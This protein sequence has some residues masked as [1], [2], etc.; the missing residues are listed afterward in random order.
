M[1]TKL[2]PTIKN[3]EKV[4]VLLP[5]YQE[6]N[7]CLDLIP[8][9]ESTGSTFSDVLYLIVQTWTLSIFCCSCVTLIVKIRVLLPRCKPSLKKFS[10]H[11]RHPST[12]PLAIAIASVDEDEEKRRC[13]NKVVRF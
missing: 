8:W 5:I 13:K 4:A 10:P 6:N 3:A 11:P 7:L 2:G 12:L 9:M 1:V